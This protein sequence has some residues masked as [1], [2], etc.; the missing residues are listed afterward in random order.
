MKK[1]LVTAFNMLSNREVQIL[2]QV[3]IYHQLSDNF[4]CIHLSL[5]EVDIGL[6]ADVGTLQRLPKIVG[7]DSLVR[8]LVYT[9]RKMMADEA[10]QCGLVRYRKMCFILLKITK[11]R[12]FFGNFEAV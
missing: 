2:L 11:S 12:T 6:A 5:Q 9:A 1:N 10:M 3:A 7:N 8:E 4:M